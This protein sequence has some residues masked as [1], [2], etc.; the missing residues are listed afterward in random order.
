MNRRILLFSLRTL[1]KYAERGESIEVTVER[2][3]RVISFNILDFELRETGNNFHQI[4]EL[5]YREEPRA[6]MVDNFQIHHLILPKFAKI[7]PNYN[8]PL[9]VWLQ[10]FCL[11]QKFKKSLKEVIE[12]VPDLKTLYDVDPGFA[13]FVERHGVVASA[14]GVRDA[15]ERWRIELLVNNDERA[16]MTDEARSEGIDIGKDERNM[17]IA[18]IVFRRMKADDDYLEAIETLKSYN[19]PDNIIKTARKTVESEKR[20]N[21]GIFKD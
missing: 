7:V 6:R 1:G 20:N 21:N 4:G 17:E 11:A 2:M 8:N 5:I 3:P 18:L 14:P 9:H 16:F 19:I 10:T 13:Q 12:M 15:Y